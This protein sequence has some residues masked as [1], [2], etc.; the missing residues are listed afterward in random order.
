MGIDNQILAGSNTITVTE[1]FK[2]PKKQEVG[3]NEFVK[4]VQ[5]ENTDK[6][7]CFVRVFMNFSDSD[8]RDLAQISPDGKT[9]Y[10][11][12]VYMSPDALV[13]PENWVYIPETDDLLGGYYYYTKAVRRNEKTTPLMERIL[14]TYTDAEQIRDF[15]VLV[16]ADSIQT[17]INEEQ[18]DGSVTAKDISEEADG[19][20]TAWTEYMEGR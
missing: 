4:K 1:D 7:D 10:Q 17:W 8:V 2:P 12:S 19:W 15:D 18:E 9:W 14:I 16:T 13:L 20:I 6:T 5:I 3:E 11:A